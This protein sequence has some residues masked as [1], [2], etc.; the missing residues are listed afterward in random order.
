MRAHAGDVDVEERPAGHH[1]PAVHREAAHREL[2]PVVHAEQAV[3]GK[4][5][6]QAVLEHGARAAQALLGRLEDEVHCAVESPGGGEVAR[7]AQQHGGVAVVAAGVHAPGVLRAVREGVG[8]FDRQRVHVGAQAHAARRVAVAQHPDHAGAAHA[9]MHL[10]AE[11]GELLGHQGGGA[12]LLEAELG[13]GVDVSPPGLH[14]AVAFLDE[15]NDLHGRLRDEGVSGRLNAT[16]CR[17]SG[18]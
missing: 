18:R 10:D 9:A 5:L 7:R 14:L 12:G 2:G 15:R 13:V 11:A 6:E 8:F 1:R 16:P 3:A 4:A 17:T